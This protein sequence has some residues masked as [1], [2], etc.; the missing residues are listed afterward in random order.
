VRTA[1]VGHRRFRVRS[2]G[3]VSSREFAAFVA[4]V[5][6][7]AF[8]LWLHK[9][10]ET[11]ERLAA[12]VIANAQDRLRLS[13][14]VVRKKVTSGPTLPGKLADCTSQDATRTELFLVEGDSAGGFAKEERSREFSGG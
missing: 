8:S 5:V 10:P 12:L 2:K 14:K 13:K 3:R 6:Q 1:R 4:G 7:N 9:H 11:G